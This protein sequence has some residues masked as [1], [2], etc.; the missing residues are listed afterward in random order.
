MTTADFLDDAGK[1]IPEHCRGLVRPLKNRTMNGLADRKP[2][3]VRF[4][5]V[6]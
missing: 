5:V 3:S 1:L 2:Q 4:T 6:A